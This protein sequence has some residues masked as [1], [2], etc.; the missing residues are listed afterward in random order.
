VQKSGINL[1]GNSAA[2]IYEPVTD[3]RIADHPPISDFL[4]DRIGRDGPYSL[5]VFWSLT[6]RKDRK[7]KDSALGNLVS[8]FLHNSH[9]PIGYFVRRLASGRVIG[10]DQENDRLG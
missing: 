10:S 2:Q 9:D 4:A 5:W 7:Q 6:T 1:L 3:V 8:E